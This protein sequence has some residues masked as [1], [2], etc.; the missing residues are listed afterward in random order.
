MPIK[1]QAALPFLMMW[2]ESSWIPIKPQA[3]LPL[4][5][6]A[7]RKFILFYNNSIRSQLAHTSTIPLN[8]CYLPEGQDKS[9]HQ[10]LGIC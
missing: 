3:T 8:T 6:D 2:L 5:Y 10:R 7:A 9:I 1:P 4:S